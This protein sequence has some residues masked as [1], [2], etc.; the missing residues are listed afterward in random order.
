MPNSFFEPHALTGEKR[1]RSERNWRG[2][3]RLVLQVQELGY[4]VSCIGGQIDT[5][6]GTRWRDATTKDIS[7]V[8][9]DL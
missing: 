8:R 1:H 5:E 6:R 3:E 2:R 7:Q 4:I 9:G